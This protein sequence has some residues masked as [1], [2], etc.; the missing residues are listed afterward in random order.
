VEAIQALKSKDFSALSAITH[1][2]RGLRFSPYGYIRSEDLVFDA[3]QVASL[4]SDPANRLWGS[5]DGSGEPIQM[6][7][8]EYYQRFVYDVDFAR[9]QI[10]AFGLPVGK[11]NTI[12]NIAE[13]YP[14][15]ILEFHFP[16]FDPQYSGMDWRSLRLVFDHLTETTT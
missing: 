1:P 15:A 10:I 16:G 14:G 7:F 8:N 9:P 11:G 13:F 5:F 6:A 3:A 12:N 4:P 2:A